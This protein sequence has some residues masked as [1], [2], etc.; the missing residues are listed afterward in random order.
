MGAGPGRREYEGQSCNPVDPDNPVLKF[1]DRI[2]RIIRIYRITSLVFAGR[3]T[4]G[5]STSW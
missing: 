3:M 1:L 4:K 5:K 2:Y